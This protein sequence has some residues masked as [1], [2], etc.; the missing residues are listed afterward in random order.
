MT[1][2]RLWTAVWTGFGGVASP[3]EFSRRI[4]GVG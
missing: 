1:R 2:L 4:E 3:L